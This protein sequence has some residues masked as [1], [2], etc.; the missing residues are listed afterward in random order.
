MIS[1]GE[2]KSEREEKKEQ[3]KEESASYNFMRPQN[4]LTPLEAKSLVLSVILY[5]FLNQVCAN[6]FC[7]AICHQ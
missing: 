7:L 6:K 5:F 1:V 3:K 2:K 4:P